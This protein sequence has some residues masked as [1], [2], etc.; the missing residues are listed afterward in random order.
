VLATPWVIPDDADRYWW[1][2]QEDWEAVG[3]ER[4]D[5]ARQH[6]DLVQ[7][8]SP[9]VRASS[10]FDEPV[11][12]RYP[13]HVDFTADEYVVNLSTQSGNKDLPP[14]ARE[15]LFER[16]RRRIEAGG[17]TLRAHLLA[18]LVVARRRSA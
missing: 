14:D 10:L 9:S 16:V 13:F 18:V 6:P 5:V 11:V 3:A 12:R 2:V 8:L 15:E 17:G 7:D 1:D 4:Y